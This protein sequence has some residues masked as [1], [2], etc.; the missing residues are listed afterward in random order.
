MRGIFVQQIGGHKNEAASTGFLVQRKSCVPGLEHS[1]IC[2][3]FKE[4]LAVVGGEGWGRAIGRR[5]AAPSFVLPDT[6]DRRGGNRPNPGESGNRWRCKDQSPSPS[7]VSQ[8]VGNV[9][10]SPG[11]ASITF[12]QRNRSRRFEDRSCSRCQENPRGAGS[13]K[14]LLT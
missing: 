10:W 4:M 12:R 6:S 13:G 11:I 2:K 9:Q 8:I 3:E 5:L 1:L 7:Q 14:G